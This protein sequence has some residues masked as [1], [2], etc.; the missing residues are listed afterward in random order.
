MTRD[1][2]AHG[3]YSRGGLHFIADVVNADSRT[4]TPRSRQRLDDADLPPGQLVPVAPGLFICTR[5]SIEVS[6]VVHSQPKGQIRANF[7]RV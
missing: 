5:P 4:R 6:D 2:R 1:R 3:V 7:W